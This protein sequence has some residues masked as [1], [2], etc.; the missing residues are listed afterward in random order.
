[1]P[2]CLPPPLQGGGDG[3]SDRMRSA[4][5]TASGCLRECGLQDGWGGDGVRSQP[6]IAAEPLLHV[7][8][9]AHQTK[10]SRA[11]SWDATDR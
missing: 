11:P 7:N 4:V 9:I 2:R 3:V 6:L 10:F 5:A 8:L 1:M